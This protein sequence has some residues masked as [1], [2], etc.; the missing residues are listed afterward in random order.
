MDEK[1]TG[2]ARSWQNL[3]PAYRQRLANA[4]ITQ[5]QYESGAS[6]AAARGHGQTPERPERAQRNPQKY[7]KYL[8]N[9][10][11]LVQMV[12][13]RK[14]RLF[15]HTERYDHIHSASYV[16]NGVPNL[17]GYPAEGNPPSVAKL[18]AILK[19]TDD[20]WLRR[21]R[22]QVNEDSFLWYH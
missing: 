1:G 19:E 14:T 2:V 13:D 22:S 21:A 9:R 4:G 15:G 18:Q 6:L 10:D 17:P 16:K 8:N 5:T 11:R 12:I 3:T 7:R 20:Q